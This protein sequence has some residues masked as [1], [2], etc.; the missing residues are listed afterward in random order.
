[1]REDTPILVVPPAPYPEQLPVHRVWQQRGWPLYRIARL[2][3]EIDLPRERVKLY[4]D[5]EFCVVVAR[6]L[7]LKLVSPPDDFLATLPAEWLHRRLWAATLE[8]LRGEPFPLFVKPLS[9]KLF[10]AA[11]YPGFGALLRATEGLAGSTPV[12]ASEPVTFACEAR[13]LVLDA[14][15]LSCSVYQ[16]EG[17]SEEAGRFAQDLLRLTHP[18]P[19]FVVDVG[20]IRGRGWAVIEANAVWGAGLNG[21]DPSAMVD[22]VA[23]AC[24]WVP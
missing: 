1:M 6:A 15:V 10:H 12:I 2:S 22:C 24:R 5:F 7:D 11:V 9:P 14:K 3:E 4:G 21:C 16:G 19:T 23:A 18:A 13:C 8:E 20:Y 17:S